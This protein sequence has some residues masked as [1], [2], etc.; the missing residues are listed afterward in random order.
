MG[1]SCVTVVDSNGAVSIADDLIT[2]CTHAPVGCK[3]VHVG[4]NDRPMLNHSLIQAARDGNA[5]GIKLALM[6]GAFPDARRAW[7]FTS[8]PKKQ[9]DNPQMLGS[10]GL[11]PLM[12]AAKAECRAGM[13]LLLDAG[14]NVNAEDED[15]WRPLHFAAANADREGCKLLLDHGAD[16]R[17][18]DDENCEALHYVP[19]E[20]T[21]SSVDRKLWEELLSSPAGC[22][23]KGRVGPESAG[24]GVGAEDDTSAP[25][26]KPVKANHNKMPPSPRFN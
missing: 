26:P 16:P 9:G 4:E 10:V 1:N 3:K 5:I 23:L 22:E 7:K 21:F 19:K 2:E 25:A 11:T 17:A 6:K 20:I 18:E 15:G 13:K 8:G 12:L 14:A 24:N